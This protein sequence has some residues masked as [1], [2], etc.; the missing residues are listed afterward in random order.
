[1][2]SNGRDIVVIDE[3]DVLLSIFHY[4]PGYVVQQQISMRAAVK[5]RNQPEQPLWLLMSQ[6]HWSAALLQEGGDK[7][8]ESSGSPS[9]S[10]L[11]SGSPPPDDSDDSD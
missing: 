1:M 3:R 4:R 11:D 6:G 9:L 8:D 10:D 5:M 7:S 2:D